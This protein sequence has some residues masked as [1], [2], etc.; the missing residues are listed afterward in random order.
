MT[1]IARTIAPLAALAVAL[2]AG[3]GGGASSGAKD[4]ARQFLE[5]ITKRDTSA[6]A[7][8]F[9]YDTLARQ[10]NE[11]WDSLPQG[12]RA[13]ITDQVRQAK[14]GE[15]MQWAALFS[16]TE[17]EVGEVRTAETGATVDLVPPEGPAIP[18]HLVQEGEAW[19]VL[20]IGQ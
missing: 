19:K 13:L 5:A 11:D 15:L 18:L 10:Q 12:Q 17:Y 16:S 2:A 8:L 14:V 1:G 9:A 20:R 3:C 7:D 4:A 6:A